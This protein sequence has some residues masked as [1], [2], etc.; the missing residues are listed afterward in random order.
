MEARSYDASAKTI[1][2][3]IGTSFSRQGGPY[4]LYYREAYQRYACRH[5]E[6]PTK[7]RVLAAMRLTV[8]LFL[9]HLWMVWREAEG[10]PTDVTGP[11][12]SIGEPTPGPWDMVSPPSMEKRRAADRVAQRL[13]TR[14]VRRGRPPKLV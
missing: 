13:G 6:W 14:T 5:P 3:L 8:K 2:F 7:H 1:C 9:K 10:T 11:S 4:K 12:D